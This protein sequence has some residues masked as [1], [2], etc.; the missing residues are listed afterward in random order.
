MGT[1]L[2][3]YFP[4]LRDMDEKTITGATDRKADHIELTL[5]SQVEAAYSD[6]RFYY[7]P[8]FSSHPDPEADMALNFAGGRLKFPLWVS[9]MTGGTELAGKINANLARMCGE[10]GFGMGL[11][12][13]RVLL[14]SRERFA[15][16]DVRDLMGSDS[17]LYANL[18]IAQ[19]ET[20]L[21]DKT[22]GA[23]ETLINDLRADGLMIHVN[24]LQEWMQP[25]GDHV[26]R[27]P[28][29]TIR[30]FVESVST[31]VI[32]KEVGQGMGPES[33]RVLLR[34]PIQ[35]V[36][37]AAHG[38]TNF[39][40]L[41][42][43]RAHAEI[44]EAYAQ[45]ALVGHSAEEMVDFVNKAIQ[46]SGENIKCRQIIISGGLSGFLDGHYLMNRVNLPSVYGHASLFLKY[47]KEDYES[48]R[49]FAKMQVEGLK[50]AQ[51]CLKVR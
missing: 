22:T 49:R 1:T 46:D 15:D 14:K 30:E 27:P 11:G 45:M 12:S 42:L 25:E 17:P 43:L 35:A 7:E 41:E 40:K 24:P 38:G 18:G 33:L 39:T 44:G 34:L 20:S 9:S 4:S 32:V 48:L 5:R 51:A 26:E 50:L 3:N 8:M 6:G 13:C 21:R 28:I 2:Q 37:F 23:I 36:E 29:E 31:R 16:F 47:A 10:F 19:I